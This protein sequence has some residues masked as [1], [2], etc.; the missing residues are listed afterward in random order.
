MS[1]NTYKYLFLLFLICWGRALLAPNDRLSGSPDG[2]ENPPPSVRATENYG[3]VPAKLLER[4]TFNRLPILF[5][6]A[7][8]IAD[9]KEYISI[10]GDDGAEASRVFIKRNGSVFV[11][12]AVHFQDNQAV[13]QKI[14]KYL[15]RGSPDITTVYTDRMA[16]RSLGFHPTSLALI[17]TD[18]SYYLITPSAVVRGTAGNGPEAVIDF[19]CPNCGLISATFTAQTCRNCTECLG[20]IGDPHERTATGYSKH[21]EGATKQ[22]AGTT[23]R[24]RYG[25][26]SRQ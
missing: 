3:S 11:V 16:L 26:K 12:Q 1:G 22:K 10:T 23:W 6:Q 9:C 19:T 5:N 24:Q 8:P 2:G 13:S 14:G 20:L 17:R 4:L 25:N 15:F 7:L 18:R 21:A